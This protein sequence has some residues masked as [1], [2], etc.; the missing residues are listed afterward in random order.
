MDFN[1]TT[2]TISNEG[3]VKSDS[4]CTPILRPVSIEVSISHR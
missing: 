4:W 2:T 3:I 1:A